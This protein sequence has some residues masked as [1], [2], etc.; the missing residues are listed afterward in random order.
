[1]IKLKHKFEE[2]S[3]L[4]EYL[5]VAKEKMPNLKL[6]IWDVMHNLSAVTVSLIL[7]YIIGSCLEAFI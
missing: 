1:V 6:L 3:A 2:L 4:R 7:G 5:Q